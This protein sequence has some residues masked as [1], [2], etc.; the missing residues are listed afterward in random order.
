MLL[1]T[2]SKASAAPLGDEIKMS[3]RLP[4]KVQ[5]DL[6]ASIRTALGH[7]LVKRLPL[8]FQPYFNQEIRRWKAKFPYEQ[9]YLECVLLYLDSLPADQLEGL[10]SSLRRIEGAMKLDPLQFS[11]SE[12]TILASSLLTRSP[13]YFEWR[14]EVDRVFKQINGSAL[15]EEQ[16]RLAGINRLLL[17]VFPAILPVDPQTLAADWPS[18]RLMKLDWS[19]N[20]EPRASLLE[21]IF[22]GQ[23]Q[24]DGKLG[25]GF[26]EEFAVNRGR[27]F[28]DVW[29]LESGTALRELLPGLGA[30]P[31]EQ[32]QAILLSFE[33]L[34][35]FREAFLEQIK[36]MQRD[37]ADA[38]AIYD[39]LRAVDVKTWCPPEIEEMPVV[40]EFL[41]SLFLTGNGAPLL[42]SA[43]VEWGAAQAVAQ[44]RPVVLVGEF[45]IRFKPKPFTSVAVFENQAK[46][47]PVPDTPDP[48]GSAIDAGML[49]YY[50]W[51]A[52]QR[53]PECGR[54]ACLCLFENLPYVFVAGAADFPIWKEAEPLVPQRVAAILR[55]WLA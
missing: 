40:Q 9:R 15:A 4:M 42:S 26:L 22:K 28:G 24:A 52:T 3:S 2:G 21:T 19:G 12:Q 45:G 41:R 53:F 46:A 13:Y 35:A 11:T 1:A 37:L 30:S 23:P 7:N 44:A 47:S 10:F 27:S 34:K 32:P 48:E 18:G 16:A 36:S 54:T 8:T 38:D 49:A 5:E 29:I 51:L 39:R 25:P 50:A 43:F 6:P 20:R 33:R 55:A 17:L 31:Q 14:Q